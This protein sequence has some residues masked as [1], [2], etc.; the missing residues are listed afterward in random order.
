MDK[1]Q[2]KIQIHQANE[3]YYGSREGKILGSEQVF[4]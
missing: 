3:K 2:R 1:K 4:T